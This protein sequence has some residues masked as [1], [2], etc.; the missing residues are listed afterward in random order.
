MLQ[1]YFRFIANCQKML[2]KS[3]TNYLRFFRAKE[4]K[5]RPLQ[6]RILE[7]SYANAR[8]SDRSCFWVPAAWMCPQKTSQAF[9]WEPGTSCVLKSKG[10][11]PKC[12]RGAVV[13]MEDVVVEFDWKEAWRTFHTDPA[14]VP[15]DCG[16]AFLVFHYLGSI[17]TSE[18]ICETVASLLKFFTRDARNAAPDTIVAR[19]L[20]RVAG[21][22]GDSDD[23][24]ILR[25]WSEIAGPGGVDSLKFHVSRRNHK[26]RLRRFHLGKGSKTLHHYV[27]KLRLRRASRPQFNAKLVR[28]ALVLRAGQT[29]SLT[30][31]RKN[32]WQK[33]HTA[34]TRM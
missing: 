10:V 23:A 15:M 9:A 21:W 19:T 3:Q 24:Y 28:R 14:Y 30:V 4:M 8:L 17:K 12:L 18:A 5:I 20:M 7:S 33:R 2:K 22:D 31:W 1:Q 29:P 25:L 11:Q 6:L 32:A 26:K 16:G 27:V 34:K 13:L